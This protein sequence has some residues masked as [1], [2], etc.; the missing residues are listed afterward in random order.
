MF[1]KCTWYLIDLYLNFYGTLLWCLSQCLRSNIVIVKQVF[2]YSFLFMVIVTTCYSYTI[3][4]KIFNLKLGH[5][6]NRTSLAILLTRLGDGWA[7]LAVNYKKTPNVI[8]NYFI[9]NLQCFSPATSPSL[10]D[11]KLGFISNWKFLAILLTVL[12][13]GWAGLVVVKKIIRL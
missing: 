11:L 3:L 1:N 13:D 6:S 9:I 12:G 7:G 5:I 10:L 4:P 8:F 2:N